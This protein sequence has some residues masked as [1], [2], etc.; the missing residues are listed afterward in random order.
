MNPYPPNGVP[1]DAT[2][3]PPNAPA[4]APTP[5]SAHLTPTQPYSNQ[6]IR[7]FGT[8]GDGGST[9]NIW[10]P[11]AAFSL[12]LITC[13]IV[14][15]TGSPGALPDRVARLA[16]AIGSVFFHPPDEALI[17]IV[18]LILVSIKTAAELVKS[19]VRL[20]RESNVLLDFRDRIRIIPGTP[21]E[22]DL[23]IALQEANADSALVRA[24]Q[25]V[26]DAR[27]LQSV[28][29]EAISNAA[30]GLELRHMGVGRTTAN[31]LMLLSLLGT[32]MG[33][34][35][36]IGSLQPQLIAAQRSGDVEA[37]LSNLQG[38]L[39]SMG[40]AFAS[41]AWG[42]VLAS[43]I[44][45]YAG[46]VNARR[47]SHVAEVQYLVVTEVAP[48]ILPLSVPMAITRITELVAQ[49]ESLISENRAVLFG[50]REESSVHLDR[51]RQHN[52]ASTL[53]MATFASAIRS[54]INTAVQNL[55]DGLV[56]AG[57]YAVQGAGV[58][59]DIAKQLED[60]LGRST[61]SMENAASELKVSLTE[62]AGS[63]RTMQHSYR[64]M[65]DSVTE[66][67]DALKGQA[68]AIDDVIQ[69]RLVQ[70]MSLAEANQ[71]ALNS[72]ADTLVGRLNASNSQLSEILKR[73]EPKLPTAKDWDRL[74][75]ILQQCTEAAN[76]FAATRGDSVSEGITAAEMQQLLSTFSS[77]IVEA[78]PS[79][80][81]DIQADILQ[82]QRE[83]ARLRQ[84]VELFSQT[85]VELSQVGS[86]PG[87]S[88][89]TPHV[90]AKRHHW[91][92]S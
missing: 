30:F 84:T 57:R 23:R 53:E 73:A 48:R 40:T 10:H 14:L 16:G 81:P 33:L 9:N 90:P 77:R 76:S 63:A 66:L 18:S 72:V 2:P 74:Q 41:T 19:N 61:A 44:A 31:R 83:I 86:P 64:A 60:L 26:W 89:A 20:A 87:P 91:P 82:L 7:C 78:Q 45:W 75:K 35:G 80:L 49:S 52:Q 37:L 34:A 8:E 22:T 38:T 25:G 21:S 88:E 4:P 67:R 13:F 43:S 36:V 3:E 1:G 79:N 28:D 39:T 29:L 50:I 58:L 59:I 92:W 5:A 27:N 11:V 15:S 32:V 70:A 54:T 6:A 85:I 69:G 51:L 65:D 46:R 12:A 56:E 42:I 62:L 68:R 47:A 71:A 55:H 17:V 24:L